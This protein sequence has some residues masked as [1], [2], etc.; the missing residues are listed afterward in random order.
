MEIGFLHCGPCSISLNSGFTVSR[1]HTQ[2]GC[3]NNIEIRSSNRIDLH[4]HSNRNRVV[5]MLT[6]VPPAANDKRGKKKKKRRGEAEPDRAVTGTTLESGPINR[7]QSDRYVVLPDGE[8]SF[9]DRDSLDQLG[10]LDKNYAKRIYKQNV[11]HNLIWQ[12]QLFAEQKQSV[13]FILQGQHT[14]GKNEVMRK[15]SA[16]L[17]PNGYSVKSFKE[18]TVKESQYNFLKRYHEQV[19]AKGQIGFWIR[20][21]YEDVA[22]AVL[23]GDVTEEEA[24]LRMQLIGEFEK[25]LM[26][27][28]IKIVKIFLHVSDLA[29]FQRL[30]ETL[31]VPKYQWHASAADFEERANFFQIQK[32]WEHVLSKTSTDEAPWYVVPSSLKWI[33]NAVVSQIVRDVFSEMNPEIP[34]EQFARVTLTDLQ[35][36]QT[37][38]SKPPVIMRRTAQKTSQLIPL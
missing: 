25:M 4:S 18:P 29:A 32:R 34:P 37:A 8:F 15:I 16:G 21:W 33:R 28:G 36:D 27:Q 6:E 11:N 20:S 14:S 17:H 30:E 26:M 2:F 13:L 38:D 5:R 24:E 1:L 22:T 12:T 10:L 7:P 19:P 9:R 3:H 23:R 31:Q 35:S